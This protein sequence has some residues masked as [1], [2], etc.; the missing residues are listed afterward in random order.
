MNG[1]GRLLQKK[2]ACGTGASRGERKHSITPVDAGT[3]ANPTCGASA[4]LADLYSSNMCDVVLFCIIAVDSI[5]FL[6]AIYQR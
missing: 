6:I 3:F 2:W 4:R 5:C 1:I